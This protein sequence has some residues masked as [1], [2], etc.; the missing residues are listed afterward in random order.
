MHIYTHTQKS[1]NN[2]LNAPCLR[3]FTK[4]FRSQVTYLI[5]VMLAI[6]HVK[7]SVHGILRVGST[8]LFG[9][10]IIIMLVKAGPSKYLIC[11]NV[12][13]L[14]WFLNSKYGP[15][16]ISLHYIKFHSISLHCIALHCIA[17]HGCR[18]SENDHKMWTMVPRSVVNLGNWPICQSVQ[19]YWICCI[20]SFIFMCSSTL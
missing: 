18:A 9:L 5:T 4:V 7:A 19:F 12:G 13:T 11:Y 6:V 17:F 1:E 2:V 10:L 8:F 14:F 3:H 20:F 15:S 16:C